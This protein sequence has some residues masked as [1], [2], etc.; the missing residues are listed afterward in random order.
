MP[1]G[2]FERTG[3]PPPPVGEQGKDFTL[4]N[5]SVVHTDENGIPDYIEVPPEGDETTPESGQESG[6][7]YGDVEPGQESAEDA[8]E[9]QANETLRTDA[10]V[11]GNRYLVSRTIKGAGNTLQ[12]GKERIAAGWNNAKEQ[13]GLLKDKFM[14]GLA[15]SSYDRRK[16]KL[17][18]VAHLSDNHPLKN[19]RM[20]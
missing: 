7:E 13:P 3:S 20:R 2:S 12:W 18:E 4:D 19:R 6:A 15:K 5:G 17:D 11:L 9:V 10:E 8:A 1:A 16:A 14:H